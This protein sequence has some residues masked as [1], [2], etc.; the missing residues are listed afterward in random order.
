MPINCSGPSLEY[1]G[2]IVARNGPTRLV[3]EDYATQY[4]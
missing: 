2:A 1:T 4:F 3:L